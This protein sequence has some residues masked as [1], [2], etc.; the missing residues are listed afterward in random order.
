MMVLFGIDK[1]VAEAAAA[2]VSAHLLSFL[3]QR[4]V[5]AAEQGALTDFNHDWFPGHAGHYAPVCNA[6]SYDC[7]FHSRIHITTIL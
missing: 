6:S 1:N 7:G 2:A 4:A 5:D 3:A